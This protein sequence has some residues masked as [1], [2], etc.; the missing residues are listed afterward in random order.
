MYHLSKVIVHPDDSIIKVIEVID[1]GAIQIALVVDHTGRLVGTVTDGDIR[2]SILAGIPLTSP[3]APIM[4]C[5]PIVAKIYDSRETI[6]SL[7]LSKKLSHIPIVDDELRLISL[8]TLHDVYARN[9]DNVVVLMAGGLGS[10][11]RPITNTCPKP[12]INIGSKP[13][14]ETI[15]EN[16]I[17]YGF[18]RFYISVNYKAEMFYDYFGDGSKWGVE[19]NYINE[20]KQMGTAG[21]LAMLPEG[22]DKPIIV[23]NGDIL[24]KINF[25]HLLD[26]HNAGKADA[27]M[28]VREYSFQVP[29]GVVKLNHDEL[30]GIEEKPE[31]HFFVNGGIYV[32]E[33][34]VLKLI[35]KDEFFDM[36][37]L[38][39][40]L[41]GPGSK[42]SVFPIR[43]Y[44]LDIGKNDDL[45]RAHE[46]F[47]AFFVKPVS[48][49]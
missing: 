40:K 1:A 6:A 45:A 20:S 46:D 34:D 25:K 36:P 35:P 23:M 12:L 8:D 42:A 13:I 18:H 37:Q 27:T 3:V 15:L 44:W 9:Q 30:L 33:P 32:L 31:H 38:F 11:L 48:E 41:I 22:I 5:T 16:F 14:L 39:H 10:R 47:P 24:T 29:Y 28:C 49:E 2:R 17:L 21:A 43:E 26:F 19:I 4:S 7:M